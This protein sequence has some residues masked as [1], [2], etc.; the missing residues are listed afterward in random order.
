MAPNST[1]TVAVEPPRG[2]HTSRLD[3]K[4]RCKLPAA[5]AKYF[6]DLGEN[7]IFCTTFDKRIA[8]LYPLSVWKVN[9]ELLEQEIEDVKTAR[10]LRFLSQ[11]LGDDT[12]IDGQKRV[13]IPAALR[14][15]L[16]IDGESVYFLYSRGHIQVF[17]EVV[18]QQ[19]LTG[20]MEDAEEKLA[21]FE[22]KGLR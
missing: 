16:G 9:E 15:A 6:E 17:G 10:E 8:R 18:F 11:V 1:A 22:R 7:K 13:L 4:G 5:I 14:R 2:L 20:A 3:E 21:R 19:L 12:E